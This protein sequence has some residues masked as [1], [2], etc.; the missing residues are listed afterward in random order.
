MKRMFILIT[1]VFS[2]MIHILQAP[3]S[4]NPIIQSEHVVWVHQYNTN[5]FSRFPPYAKETIP[6]SVWNQSIRSSGLHVRFITNASN[7][8]V[9]YRLSSKSDANKWF[10]P[11]GANGLDM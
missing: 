7:I 5:S 11:V 8:T 9:N 6:V 2:L 10:S 4:F 1:I 3:K